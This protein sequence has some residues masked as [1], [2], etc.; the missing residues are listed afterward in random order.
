MHILGY[1]GAFVFLFLEGSRLSYSPAQAIS[2]YFLAPA[3]LIVIGQLPLVILKRIAKYVDDVSKLP[4]YTVAILGF[5]KGMYELFS[6]TRQVSVLWAIPVA[7]LVIIVW[8][9]ITIIKDTKTKVKILGGKLTA[10]RQLKKLSFI[11]VYFVVLIL[12]FDVQGIGKPVFW[13]TPAL[14]SLGIALF[15]EGNTRK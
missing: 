2:Y 1:I 14:I 12:A 6:V 15:L 4:M 3:L 13:L 10:I 11:L 8:D 5:I 9:I 7:L